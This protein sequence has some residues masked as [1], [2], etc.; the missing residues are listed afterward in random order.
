MFRFFARLILTPVFLMI[1]WS[2]NKCQ[3]Q[4]GDVIPYMQ[5][6]NASGLGSFGA[7]DISPFTGLADISIPVFSVNEGDIPVNCTLRYMSGGVKPSAHPGWVGQNWTLD[8]GGVITRKVNGGVDEVANSEAAS[9]GNSVYED[10]YA[11]YKQYGNLNL[12]TYTPWSETQFIKAYYEPPTFAAEGEPCNLAPDE[13][14]FTLPTG[15]S[16]SFYLN[17]FGTWVVRTK[18]ASNLV[19]VPTVNQTPF[20]LT[21][22]GNSTYSITLQRIFYSI[23]ITD[24]K[25]YV[26]TYGNSPNA[27]E[28]SRG[29]RNY[30]PPAYNEDVVANAWHLTSIQSPTGNVVNFTYQRLQNL[31]VQGTVYPSSESVVN[32]N[33]QN[34]GDSYSSNST[35]ATYTAQVISPV[36][37]S[38]ISG[39]TFAANFNIGPT[40]EL[41]YPYYAKAFVGGSTGTPIDFFNY[42]DLEIQDAPTAN[43]TNTITGTGGVPPLSIWYQLNSIVLNDLNGVT[44]EKYTFSYS[45]S[46]AQ[47]LFLNEFRKV[48]LITTGAD[49]PYDFNYNL[50]PL[51]AYN[52]MQ[53]DQWGYYNGNPFPSSASTVSSALLTYFAM[54][55]TYAQAGILKKITYPTSGTTTFNYEPND[56]SY[57]LEKS[58]GLINLV[59]QSGS[60]G[61]LRIAS[62]VNTDNAGNS[63]TTQYVYKKIVNGS[64]TVSTGVLNGY[65]QIIY[66]NITIGSGNTAASLSFLNYTDYTQCLDYTDGRDV[67]YSEVQ[68]ILPDGSYVIYDYSN[69][70][71]PLYIDQTPVNTYIDAYVAPAGGGFTSIP[72][73]TVN[74]LPSSSSMELERGQLLS[75]S[76]YNAAGKLLKQIQNTYN[77][78]PLRFNSYVPSFDIYSIT[79][80]ISDATLVQ[81]CFQ[82]IK[83]YYYFPNLASTTTTMNDQNGLNPVVVAK[84]F[85]YDPLNRNLKTETYTTSNQQQVVISYNYATDPITGLSTSAQSAQ[86]AMAAAN[87]TG[88][89]LEKI[90]TRNT[91]QTEHERTDY[92]SFT[93]ANGTF[94]KPAVFNKSLSTL[95]LEPRITY[96]N[97]DPYGHLL[98]EQKVNDARH[99]YLWGYNNAYPVAEI[100]GS[101]YAQVSGLLSQTALNILANPGK[102]TGS[103]GTMQSTLNSIRTGLASAGTTALVN[104]YTYT[105]LTGMISKTDPTGK[106]TTYV[107]DGLNR[108]SQVLDFNN[109]VIKEF[110]YQFS[111]QGQ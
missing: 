30:T 107:Y 18:S 15:V 68:K 48:N 98:E 44:R 41:G 28:F 61:G 12:S 33:S 39:R 63:Y 58:G 71:N 95:N 43:V 13:F 79:A 52:A 26:Y 67:V 87:I 20:L 72:A 31:Y 49:M 105:P 57:V 1:I 19:V 46:T 35:A 94:Y 78:N 64:P 53:Q 84:S 83:I 25:G 76:D 93:G 10:T 7:Y 111:F 3:A 99:V 45:N 65:N 96:N 23:T 2:G 108:L 36:Y 51:P 88:I 55:N 14:S 80:N 92:N 54:N 47:R 90:T 27:I 40:T 11:Y 103:D 101:S 74:P 34:V 81:R 32:T 21:N 100:I 29:P 82:A 91:V 38:Q 4:Q 8:V 85:S 50:T 73:T 102:A 62:I 106:V 6:P 86:T 109:N 89:P 42:N 5:S 60:G 77:A 110:N 24:E 17:Q 69:S 37:L 66:N 97:Y 59:S 22:G 56:Y 9:P 75:E 16:G 104:T 70:D